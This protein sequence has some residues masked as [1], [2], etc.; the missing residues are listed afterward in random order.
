[1]SLL[2]NSSFGRDSWN[3]VSVSYSALFDVGLASQDTSGFVFLSIA[4]P[5]IFAN[6]PPVIKLYVK[7]YVL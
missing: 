1:M 4:K 6:I 3:T 5:T 2:F 7:Y